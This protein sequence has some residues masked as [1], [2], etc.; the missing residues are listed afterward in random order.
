MLGQEGVSWST[1]F[2]LIK[3]P[4]FLWDTWKPSK[5]LDSMKL[6]ELWDC[7]NEGER[8]C[9]EKQAIRVKPPLRLVEQ[10]FEA[11]WRSTSK[12]RISLHSFLYN[13]HMIGQARK[14]WQRFREIP[15]WIDEQ[16]R[17]RHIKTS[18]ILDEVEAIREEAGKLVGM[19]G[20]AKIIKGMR[21]AEKT[22]SI[23]T[24]VPVSFMRISIRVILIL[25]LER[26]W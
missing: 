14:A 1:V 13:I 10:H 16:V 18:A 22:A 12:V 3:Q 23:A 21:E 20:L 19:N 25:F 26:E 8:V 24:R 15:E 5:P 2:N 11:S 6:T 7:Y 9:V 17:E 4:S